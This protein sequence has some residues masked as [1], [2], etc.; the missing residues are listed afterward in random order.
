MET[1]PPP[2]NKKIFFYVSVRGDKNSTSRDVMRI[3]RIALIKKAEIRF[4]GD[5]TI[6]QKTQFLKKTTK[7]DGH[8]FQAHEERRQR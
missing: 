5:L 7:E 6:E 1:L 8:A 2:P 3:I 4:D